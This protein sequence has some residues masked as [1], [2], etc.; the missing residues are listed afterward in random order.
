MQ[1]NNVVRRPRKGGNQ[2]VAIEVEVKH[3]RCDERERAQ[4]PCNR[5]PART[6]H[7]TSERKY[8]GERIM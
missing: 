5:A 4:E 8:R 6:P 2:V 3:V 7:K 1:G